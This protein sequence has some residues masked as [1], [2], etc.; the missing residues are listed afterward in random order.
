MKYFVTFHEPTCSCY[1]QGTYHEHIYS[2]HFVNYVDLSINLAPEWRLRKLMLEKLEFQHLSCLQGLTIPP[3]I[4]K[5]QLVGHYTSLHFI[6]HFTTLARHLVPGQHC[7]DHL[8]ELRR[9]NCIRVAYTAISQDLH[10]GALRK[11]GEA[12]GEVAGGP[13]LQRLQIRSLR[14]K[15]TTG[16]NIK[17]ASI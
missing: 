6:L 3:D 11:R 14:I 1:D 7:V 2:L 9:C 17:P 4:C 16:S 5:I 8:L 15:L 13:L 10:P 12:F